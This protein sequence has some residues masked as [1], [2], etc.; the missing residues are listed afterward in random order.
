MS[1]A[2]GECPTC[3]GEIRSYD[4]WVCG[5]C[6][7]R[8][9]KPLLSYDTTA[10]FPPE[11]QMRRQTYNTM[12]AL[13]RWADASVEFM[14]ADKQ[15]AKQNDDGPIVFE[16]DVIMKG[17][18]TV[19][20]KQTTV[21]SVSVTGPPG[22]MAPLDGDVEEIRKTLGSHQKALALVAQFFHSTNTFGFNPRNEVERLVGIKACDECCG[23]GWLARDETCKK[24]GRRGYTKA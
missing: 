11:S 7:K 20:G 10:N 22:P 14:T 17:D 3:G 18:L 1:N 15:P 23:S 13:E 21:E 24:C 16:R 2:T 5:R 6:K 9:D 8:P 12:R 4:G 19:E